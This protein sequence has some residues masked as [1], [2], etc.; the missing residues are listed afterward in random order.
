MSGS[1][2]PSLVALAIVL[3]LGTAALEAS[4]SNGY[5]SLKGM[6]GVGISYTDEGFDQFFMG[7][8]QVSRPGVGTLTRKSLSFWLGYGVTDD[9]TVT[10]NLPYIRTRASGTGGYKENDF[11]DLVVMGT[12]RLYAT[13]RVARSTFV[14]AA[15][16]RTPATNYS[17]DNPAD[18][19]DGTTD[20][21]LRIIY[22]LNYRN[23]YIAQQVGYDVRGGIAPDSI[24]LYT[25]A[26][27][28][29]GRVSLSGFFSKY[30]TWEGTDIGEPFS[31]FPSNREEWDRIG[32]KVY[33]AATDRFGVSVAAFH[34]L[35]G[36][37][38]GKNTGFGF[39]VFI[40]F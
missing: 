37:N 14:G 34:V 11:Q 18:V 16:I 26:G 12:R 6:G 22:R 7:Q 3:T 32:G 1:R 28:G 39:G 24:P 19:G 35:N 33:F 2:G 36:R 40:P 25:E 20:L 29:L 8:A 30:L 5:V 15:G 38:T 21:L 31:P 27:V 4:D 17:V 9:L 10:V 13:G 23:Y